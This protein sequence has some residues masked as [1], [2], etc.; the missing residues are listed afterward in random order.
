MSKDTTHRDND[1]LAA[2]RAR[3]ERLTP[4]RLMV[5]EAVREMAGHQTAEAVHDRVR[6]RYPYANLATIYRALAWL[7]EQALVSETD[8]GGGQVEYEYL[9]ES[10]HH[11]LV[12]LRCGH[13]Q[14]FGD[15]VVAPM[16][17]ALRERYHF[18]PRID[19]LAVF[20]LCW[21]CRP[22]RTGESREQG[23]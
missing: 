15:D 23:C 6:G 22:S 18:E 10:R 20:G 1:T 14:A 13:Q 19:H 9:G 8:L 5:L 16:M 17:A 2:L 7:K 11:H 12:C 21:H 3:G 4:Q